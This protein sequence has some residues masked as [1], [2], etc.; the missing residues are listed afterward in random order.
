[1]SNTIKMQILKA[2]QPIGTIYVA[3]I[4]AQKLLRMSSVD[5]RHIDED[6]EVLGI[7]RP[8][9]ADKVREIKKYLTLQNATFPNSI[10][11]N[12]S[13]DNVVNLS[14]SEIE[15]KDSGDTFTIIDGQHR[16]YGFE[17]YNGKTFELIITI[18]VGL[19]ISLQSEVFSIINSQQTK[20]DPSLNIN[21]ELSD[22]TDNPRKML[23]QISQSFNIDKTS[24][25]YQQIKM[26]G[27]QSY[28]FI[29][30]ASFVRP[31]FK[32]TFPE[33]LFLDIKSR[34]I[35][36]APDFPDLSDLD[37]NEQRYPF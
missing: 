21:L 18:F 27:S 26:L 31:L 32:L 12:V 17:E 4:D 6:D 19:E 9:K 5:R 7:Q 10:I 25:W 20:I 15:L 22:K 13:K 35:K 28:G 2:K 16:L 34:L 33:R 29:S 8:L 24:P 1:M 11:V 23:V 37:V 14:D 3:K 36:T 30:L